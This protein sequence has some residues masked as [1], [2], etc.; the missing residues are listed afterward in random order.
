[1]R[2]VALVLWY[3]ILF[4]RIRPI[5]VNL[6]LFF[7]LGVLV[8]HSD[9]TIV[10]IHNRRSRT[11]RCSSNWNPTHTESRQMMPP[12]DVFSIRNNECAWLG[13]AK[14]LIQALKVMRQN[15]AGSYFIFFHETDHKTMWRVD[16]HGSV[17]P[18]E[19][20]S[21]DERERVRR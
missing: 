21:Q 7:T 10:L 17:R 2:C 18:V 12:L 16:E 20:E 1:M 11:A 14:T 13:P 3:R 4:V 8:C 6:V 9:R 19:A 5:I 15:G